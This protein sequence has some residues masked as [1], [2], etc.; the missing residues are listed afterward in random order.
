MLRRQAGGTFVHTE[1]TQKGFG[2]QLI[3]PVLRP[4]MV[5][6]HQRWLEGL[7]RK[8]AEGPPPAP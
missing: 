8:A 6:L 2:M 7:S 3:K 4:L 5:R 1:E